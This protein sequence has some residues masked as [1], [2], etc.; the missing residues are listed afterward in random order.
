MKTFKVTVSPA[1]MPGNTQY[2]EAETKEEA[3]RIAYENA[4]WIDGT[5]KWAGK[6]MRA[7]EYKKPVF[8]TWDYL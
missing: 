1:W 5:Y 4:K 6:T 7:V 3:K 2:V 8:T